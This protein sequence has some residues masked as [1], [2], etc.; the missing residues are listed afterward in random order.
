MT[1]TRFLIPVP[2][3][4]LALAGCSDGRESAAARVATAFSHDVSAH[5]GTDACKLLS[6]AAEESLTSDGQPCAKAVLD[7]TTGGA[8][9]STSVWGDEAQVRTGTDV[10]FL[11]QLKNGWRIRAAGCRRAEQPRRPYQCDVEA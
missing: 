10:I 6:P 1:A 5:D 4:A 2:L 11:M 9:S 7:V 8:A 3:L